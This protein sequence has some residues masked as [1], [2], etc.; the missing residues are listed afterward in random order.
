[1]KPKPEKQK[2]VDPLFDG[3]LEKDIRLMTP[4]EKLSYLSMQ[5]QLK[6][7]IEAKVKKISKI[8]QKP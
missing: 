3:H 2:Q 4:K 7:F 8:T 5:I 1:M 6:R